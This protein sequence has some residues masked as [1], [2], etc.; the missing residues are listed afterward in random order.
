MSPAKGMCRSDKANMLPAR[1]LLC[2]EW[3]RLYLG[4]AWRWAL[5]KWVWTDGANRKRSSSLASH[6]NCL[7]SLPEQLPRKQLSHLHKLSALMVNTQ[8]V[9]PLIG[10]V[11]RV[12]PSCVNGTELGWRGVL[13]GT[14]AYI[15]AVLCG[16]RAR[17]ATLRFRWWLLMLFKPLLPLSDLLLGPFAV[18][19]ARHK[20]WDPRDEVFHTSGKIDWKRSRHPSQSSGDALQLVSLSG[21]H[22]NL[23][24]F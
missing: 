13:T 3:E 19:R 11:A 6:V 7:M 16:L 1:D 4:S 14:R 18:T 5:C 23:F 9:A 20:H 17:R 2:Q 15:A 12:W 24:P 21:S 10:P 8:W 22:S